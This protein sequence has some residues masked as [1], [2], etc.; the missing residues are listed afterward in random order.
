M[1]KVFGLALS[2][3]FLLGNKLL[4]LQI[5]TFWNSEHLYLC[6]R[7]T[8]SA[9]LITSVVILQSHCFLACGYLPPFRFP[10]C[11]VTWKAIKNSRAFFYE[12]VYPISP[13]TP[14]FKKSPFTHQ[15]GTVL[16]YKKLS[17]LCLYTM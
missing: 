17:V 16:F 3:P 9:E 5:L 4:T 14:L 6:L 11:W 10:M 1:C 13:I 8:L 7:E 2:F 12:I 15:R